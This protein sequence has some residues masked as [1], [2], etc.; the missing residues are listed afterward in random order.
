[1]EHPTIRNL[2]RTGTPDGRDPIEPVCPV[3]GAD[4]ETFYKQDGEII[5]C[6]ECIDGVDA[7]EYLMNQAEEEAWC[8][9]QV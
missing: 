7:T 2:E 6:N 9:G 8:R 4:A 3:C 1:M 5:G